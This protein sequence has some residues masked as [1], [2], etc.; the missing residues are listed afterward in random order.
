MRVLS[1]GS[2]NIDYVYRVDGIVRPGE[3]KR[4]KSRGVYAGGKGLNQSIAMA[5]AGLPVF[6][7]GKVGSDGEFLIKTLRESGVDTHLIAYSGKASGHTIIQVDDEG[8]NCILLYEGANQDIDEA[9]IDEVLAAFSRGDYLV[10]QNEISHVPLIIRKAKACGFTVIMNP[11]PYTPDIEGYPLQDVDIF[12]LNEIEAEALT[13][14]SVPLEA[15]RVLCHRYPHVQVVLTRGDEGALWGRQE[16][17]IHQS[18]YPVKAVDTT[19]AGDTFLGYFIAGLVE[20]L[21]VS[22]A[23][24]LASRAAALCVTRLGAA[25]SIPWR[26][27]VG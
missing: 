2:L 4:V 14:I 6:H 5:R 15:L 27:E 11:S 22:E 19:A 13:G 8:R 7:A 25:D 16:D 18:A 9:Y 21:P 23:L 26:R 12:I 3:T 17:L 24:D 1:F 10:V 20:G